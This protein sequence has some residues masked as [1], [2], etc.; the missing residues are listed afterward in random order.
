MQIPIEFYQLRNDGVS[1]VRYKLEILLAL[2]RHG[3]P[4]KGA[5]IYLGDGIRTKVGTSS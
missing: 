5:L 4:E 3:V 1:I 2:Q